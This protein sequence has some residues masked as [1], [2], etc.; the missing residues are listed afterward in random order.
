MMNLLKQFLVPALATRPVSAV[1]THIFGAGIPIFMLHRMVRDGEPASGHTPSFL[2]QCLRSLK[3]NGHSFVSVEDILL[4]LHSNIPLPPTPVAFTMDDGF[5][6]QVT[7][8]APVFMEFNCPVT[9]FLVTG[10]ID[11]KL[12]PWF[13]QVEYLLEHSKVDSIYLDFPGGKKTFELDTPNKNSRSIRSIL[14]VIKEMD[15]E[16][17]PDTIEKLAYCTQVEIPAT[18]PENYKPI[19]WDMAREFE[20]KGIRFGPHTLSHPILSRVGDKQAEQE[21]T[22]SW[23][24]LKQ[25]LTSPSRVFCYP[26]GLLNDF[27]KREIDVI[28][29]INLLGAVSAIHGNAVCGAREKDGQY[30]LPR[31]GLPG[32]LHDFIQYSSWIEYAKERT[33]K[34]ITRNHMVATPGI[35]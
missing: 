26:N 34:S 10:M 6:D 29:D 18:P 25:E 12:W 1:A 3:E 35:A 22:G 17:V 20:K 15:W 2:R 24:R 21:I 13:C 23:Q 4:Y 28:K 14:Q 16:Q 33:R 30:K 8:A 11:G 31:F 32:S 27:G 19:S 5:E 7:L 9:I